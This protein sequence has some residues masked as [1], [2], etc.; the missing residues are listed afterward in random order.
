MSRP[1]RSRDE[2]R[3]AEAPHPADRALPEPALHLAQAGWVAAF[4]LAAMAVSG[5]L[6]WASLTGGSTAGCGPDSNC[7]EVLSSRWAHCF[8]VP[9]SALALMV[10][11]GILVC[12][13]LARCASTI[14][15]RA[16]AEAGLLVLATTV[17]GAAVWFTAAQVWLIGAVC[18]Y[19]LAAHGCGLGAAAL[20]LCRLLARLNPVI[21]WPRRIGA[22][23]LGLA[24][25]GVLIACQAVYEPASHRVMAL[26]A[27]RPVHPAT[28]NRATNPPI[29]SA[30]PALPNAAAPS[31]PA[32]TSAAPSLTQPAPVPP[33]LL[34]LHDGQFEF[35][36]REIPVLGSPDAPHVVGSLFDYTCDHCRAL[37][38]H[39]AEVLGT[40]S[41]ELVV[42]CLPVPLNTNCNSLVRRNAAANSNACEYAELALAVWRTNRAQFPAFDG[43]L[44]EGATPPSL[45]AARERAEGLVGLEALPQALADPWVKEQLR[46]N[47]ALYATNYH[48][49]GSTRIPQLMLGSR[50]SEGRMRAAEDLYQL[51]EAQ[52]GLKRPETAARPLSPAP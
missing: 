23:V 9:V 38:H 21:P 31:P 48:I 7:H 28:P 15:R 42:A 37:H 10:D 14:A 2:N 12:L 34:T 11:V 19:C 51:L 44:F 41:N 36:L 4:V 8:Q 5:Y 3:V 16:R 13:G 40:F 24:A 17:A 45:D 29:V 46:R 49:T 20:L 52:L 43:W 25:V 26:P 32:S 50:I 18:P 22:V 6:L 47:V 27:T 35:D 1:L 30:P 33:R 39:L